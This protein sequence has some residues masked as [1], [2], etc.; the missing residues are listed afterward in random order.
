MVLRVAM[1]FSAQ[2]WNLVRPKESITAPITGMKTRPPAGRMTAKAPVS[3][4]R[5]YTCIHEC[6][7]IHIYI[8]IC[9]HM[10]IYIYMYTYT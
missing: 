5:A 10:Y 8:Y 3:S 9:I 4:L 1:V 6:V 2:S 7:Y